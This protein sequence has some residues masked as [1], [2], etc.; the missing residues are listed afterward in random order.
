MD[1]RKSD[2][3]F[4]SFVF[5]GSFPMG[6]HLE[7]HVNQCLS[8]TEGASTQASST[9]MLSPGICEIAGP[10]S[11]G[12]RT[13]ALIFLRP[14]TNEK[15]ADMEI[16]RVEGLVAPRRSFARLE[17]D[18]GVAGRVAH[19]KNG[20]LRVGYLPAMFSFHDRLC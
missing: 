14:T 18:G 10:S 20:L 8:A 4:C 19:S 11:A 15:T 9:S 6:I 17:L 5:Q 2:V 3:F 7:D 1:L 16:E 12:I 13:P